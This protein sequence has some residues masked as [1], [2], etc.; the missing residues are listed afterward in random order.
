MNPKPFWVLKN[1]TVPVAMWP[2]C[3]VRV[4]LV[5]T[6]RASHAGS[7]E[8]WELAERPKKRE[9]RKADRKPGC[10]RYIG[11][12]RLAVNSV[13]S[14]CGRSAQVGPGCHSA[15]VANSLIRR[16]PLQRVI[17]AVVETLDAVGVEPFVADL[18][19][20][21]EGTH[22]RKTFDGETN[23][24]CRRRKPAIA[25]RLPGATL[26]LGH[27]QVGRCAV[28]ECHALVFDRHFSSEHQPR[29]RHPAP[30][31]GPETSFYPAAAR[32]HTG[33]LRARAL[34]RP[35]RI[36]V[37]LTLLDH[38]LMRLVRA[39]DAVLMVVAFR[40]QQLG[41]LVDAARP[42]AAVGAG[43]IEDALADLEFMIA[44]VNLHDAG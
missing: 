41:D 26:A 23:C 15:Q 5:P 36:T 31:H 13:R 43:G 38:P 39:L 8:F 11:E 19:P 32:L 10:R 28:I 9:R 25:Q 3:V 30:R 42:A 4:E 7:S 16:P 33:S 18:H 20:G 22:G 44:Q 29:P 40:R 12:R 14:V 17:A 24:F 6:A 34:R 21:A 37:E 27:E 2:P 1:F 35:S